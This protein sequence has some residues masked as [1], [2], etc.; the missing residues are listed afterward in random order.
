LLFVTG[1]A[2]DVAAGSGTYVGISVLRE[3]LEGLGCVVDFVAPPSG[4][5][6]VS[7]VRRLYFNLS[8]RD[9]A[10]GLPPDAVVGFDWDGLWVESAGAPHIASIKGVIADEASF[11]RGLPRLRLKTEARL[12]KRHVRRADRILATS[13]H[14]ASRIA[15]VYGVP[16]E[17][18][19]VVPEPIDLARWR[20]ALD[21][22]ETLPKARPSILCVAHLYPRKDVATLLEALVRVPPEVVLRVVGTG[23]GLPGLRK[24]TAQLAL[25]DRVEFLEHVPFAR[26]AAEYRRS[27]VFCLPSR[28]EGF[29]IV[30]LEA[31]AT[32]LPIVAARAAAVPEVV[33]DGECGV[34]VEP[35]NV[36]ALADALRRLMASPEERRRLG[37]AGRRRA[38]R[39]DAQR[40]ARRFLEAIGLEARAGTGPAP[41]VADSS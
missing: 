18:I 12:E 5:G 15:R 36:E 27:D 25:G 9:L 20:A 21:S 19:A 33:A 34:L 7:L 28:Q 30:F 6:P 2:P 40:V 31:M 17:R 24:R 39:Y 41:T 8:I 14:S 4:G 11:E 38:E 1:T 35:Q 37:E 3:A 26:L 16:R 29:G 32:G 23:P 10:K 22:A 13:E